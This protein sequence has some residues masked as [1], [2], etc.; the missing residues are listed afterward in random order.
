MDKS[1]PPSVFSSNRASLKK[2]TKRSAG[3][4]LE[5]VLKKLNNKNNLIFLDNKEEKL[6]LASFSSV[7]K[8]GSIELPFIKLKEVTEMMTPI[9]TI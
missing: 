4:E 5:N 2:K 1:I 3:I 7:E 6:N 9:N 8:V